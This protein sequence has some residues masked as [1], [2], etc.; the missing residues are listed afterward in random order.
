VTDIFGSGGG[1]ALALDCVVPFLG[2]IPL[3]PEFVAISDRGAIAAEFDG[4]TAGA[5]L[6]IIDRMV[7]LHSN[8]AVTS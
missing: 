5:F 4:K 2:D 3:L 1:K 8:A 6:P 7:A